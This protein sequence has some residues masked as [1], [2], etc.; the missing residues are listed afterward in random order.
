MAMA[1]APLPPGSYDSSVPTTIGVTIF[2]LSVASAAVVLRTYTRAFIIN[3]MGVDD[4]FAVASLL[5]AYGSGI[6]MLC[7]MFPNSC[8]ESLW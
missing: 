2:C 6:S 3:K 5:L 1:D 8:H 4:Y 7:S